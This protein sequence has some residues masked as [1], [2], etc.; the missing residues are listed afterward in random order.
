METM[1]S[2]KS[3]RPNPA[4][5]R[6]A[7]FLRLTIVTGLFFFTTCEK[8]LATDEGFQWWLTVF[9]EFPIL[10]SKLRGYAESN[11]RLNDGLNGMNQYLLRNALGVRR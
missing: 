1:A 10:N 8:S 9:T 3:K 2:L 4:A 5:A 6:F 7:S 11:P